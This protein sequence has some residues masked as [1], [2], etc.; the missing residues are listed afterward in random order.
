MGTLSLEDEKARLRK[1]LRKKSELLSSEERNRRSQALIGRLLKH[2]R[3]LKARTL[4]TYVALE[5]EVE[6]R[7]FVEE[8]LK[9]GKRVFVPLVERGGDR[10]QMMEISGTGELKSGTYGVWE[11]PF[12]LH[13]IGDPLELDLVIVPGVSFDREGGRLGRGK[14][15]FDRFLQEAHNAYRIGLA[16][17]YQIVDRVP[18][19]ERDRVMNEVLIG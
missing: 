11:P 14:G 1:E 15:S 8:A 2:P 13:R 6:T 19:A 12:E 16:F 7:P 3:F 4:L 10:I 5:S 18:R 9:Q 17:E